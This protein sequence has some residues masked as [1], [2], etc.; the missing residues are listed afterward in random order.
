MVYPASK[1]PHGRIVNAAGKDNGVSSDWNR[2]KAQCAT[3]AEDSE[4]LWQDVSAGGGMAPLRLNLSKGPKIQRPVLIL[5]TAVYDS[6]SGSDQVEEPS[7][8]HKVGPSQE[9]GGQGAHHQPDDQRCP[10]QL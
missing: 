2:E 8:E 6:V 9:V 3:V 5:F 4:A 7:T 1:V 10:N